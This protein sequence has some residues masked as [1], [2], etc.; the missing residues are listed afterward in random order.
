TPTPA[1]APGA[2]AP[3]NPRWVQNFAPTELWSGPSSGAVDYGP[4]PQWSYVLWVAP[5]S[6]PRL[7]VWVPWSKNYAFVDATAVGPSGP[8]PA[9]WVNQISQ[10]VQAGGSNASDWV[11]RDRRQLDRSGFSIHERG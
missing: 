3:W 10:I 2:V 9:G 8:P 7:Y 1:A 11:G 5:Q 6:G 4:L